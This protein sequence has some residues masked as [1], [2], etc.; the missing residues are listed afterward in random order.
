MRILFIAESFP[1]SIQIDVTGGVETRDWQIAVALAKTHH[2]TVVT[3]ARRNCPS[4]EK[5]RGINVV[6]IGQ[7]VEPQQRESV[8]TRLSFVLG[9][10]RTIHEMHFDLIQGSNV[11]TQAIAAYIGQ[12]MGKPIVALIPDIY[13]GSWIKNTNLITGIIGEIIEPWVLHQPWDRIISWSEA[14][15]KKLI[16]KR[17]DQKI[18]ETI[19]GGVDLQFI[20]R[21]TVPKRKNPTIVTAARLVPYKRIDI[22]IQTVARLSK[23]YPQIKLYIL[24]DGPDKKRLQQLVTATNGD[25]RVIF[26]GQVTSFSHVVKYF[27]SAHLFSLPSEIEGFGLAT[28]EA[29]A[30]GLPYVNLNIPATREVTKN[31]KGGILIESPNVELLTESINKLL[32]DGKLYNTKVK[33]SHMLSRLYDWSVSVKKTEKIFEKI[34]AEDHSSRRHC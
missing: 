13:I 6:R 24:G 4:E 26:L 5:M 7:A 14:T 15:T 28:L 16:E 32:S 9:C 23:K 25:S 11:V 30:C 34:I 3:N 8:F 17:V 1:T 27:K 10:M 21:F 12:Q 29:C 33:E 18:I 19:P 22:L 20:Q 2:V 31:G